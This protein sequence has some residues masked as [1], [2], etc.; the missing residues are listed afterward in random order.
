V[1]FAA[2]QPAAPQGSAGAEFAGG[3]NT[4]GG[5]PRGGEWRC[6]FVEEVTLAVITPGEWRTGASHK[7]EQTCVAKVDVDAGELPQT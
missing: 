1:V 5:L 4:P 6:M 7:R 3:G 2:A